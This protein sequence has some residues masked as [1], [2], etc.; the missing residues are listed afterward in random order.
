MRWFSSFLQNRW[1]IETQTNA[2]SVKTKCCQ[3]CRH[4]VEHPSTSPQRCWRTTTMEEQSTGGISSLL[5]VSFPLVFYQS[6][7]FS[8]LSFFKHQVGSGGGHVWDDGRKA[9]LLQQVGLPLSP[10][11]LMKLMTFCRDHDILFELILMEDVRFPKTISSEAK[12]FL[13]KLLIK[14]PVDRLGGGPED[15]EWDLSIFKVLLSH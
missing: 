1:W 9:P 11:V 14:T 4:F 12:D 5:F 6:Q 13:S 7:V 15:A 10:L 2:H 8:S 3:Y